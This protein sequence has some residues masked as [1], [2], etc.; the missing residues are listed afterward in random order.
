MCI[1][2]VNFTPVTIKEQ[3]RNPPNCVPLPVGI[4]GDMI[5]KPS[6]LGMCISF[7]NSYTCSCIG[8]GEKSSRL[9]PSVC[10]YSRW[11][12]S[13]AMRIWDL[14]KQCQL[15]YLYVDMSQWFQM[16]GCGMFSNFV[17][18]ARVS[19]ICVLLLGFQLCVCGMWPGFDLFI[20][21]MLPK[22]YLLCCHDFD[23]F[24]LHIARAFIISLKH[25][26]WVSSIWV[27]SSGFGVFVSLISP[28]F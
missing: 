26:I 1:S 8:T 18:V 4:T 3:V 23:F 16:V 7:V 28:G 11:N 17:F 12:D 21:V 10:K 25:V 2:C 27:M 6:G 9:C 14:Y 20:C 13:Q 15:Q 24:V 22:G 5:R 19:A